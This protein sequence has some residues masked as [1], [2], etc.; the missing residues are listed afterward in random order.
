MAEESLLRK[1]QTDIGGRFFWLID[2]EPVFPCKS[3]M[4]SKDRDVGRLPN[5]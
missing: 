2:N 1:R 4:N 3:D 5:S